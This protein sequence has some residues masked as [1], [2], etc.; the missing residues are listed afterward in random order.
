MTVLFLAG[1]ARAGW[2]VYYQVSYED[3]T[4][5]DLDRPPAGKEGVRRVLRIARYHPPRAGREVLSTAAGLQTYHAGRTEREDLHWDGA[6]WVGGPLGGDASQA[7]G[8]NA[9]QRLLDEE[10][11]RARELL[12]LARRRVAEADHAIAELTRRLEAA[13][14]EAA[15]APAESETATARALRDRLAQA[16]ELRRQALAA[17]AQFARQ[18]R[19]LEAL[20]AA[21][22]AF[23]PSGELSAAQAPQGFSA[24]APTAVLPCRMMV[25]PLERLEGRRTYE[26][27]S[28][29][30]EAG[31]EGE[32][33]YVAFAD[34][35][36]DGVPDRRLG[37]SAPARARRPGGWTRWR[38][39]TDAESVFVGRAWA[40]DDVLHATTSWP[41]PVDGGPVIG[42]EVFVSGF[43][44]GMPSDRRF[45]P[46][47]SNLRV[48]LVGDSRV[49]LP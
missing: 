24:D 47:I 5:R 8:P 9:P 14:P 48:R 20:L 36:G 33:V 2:E 22:E 16:R 21:D 45:W 42:E 15:T 34:T 17:R 43:F 37:V 13:E 32:V 29:H 35:D 3:G 49:D 44:G 41:A 18:V 46:Y 28:P 19:A 1:F 27:A 11:R 31:G 38:F 12:E 30:P 4:V 7:A 39:S 26:V 6:A 40:R 23:R 10:L 25:L